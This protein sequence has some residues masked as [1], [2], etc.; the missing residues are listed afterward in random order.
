M[1][2]PDEWSIW[3]ESVE[4]RD[5]PGRTEL[6]PREDMIDQLPLIINGAYRNL[7]VFHSLWQDI[8]ACQNCRQAGSLWRNMQAYKQP[9]DVAH[10]NPARFT[11]TMEPPALQQHREIW[12]AHNDSYDDY[13]DA[14]TLEESFGDDTRFGDPHS[15]WTIFRD[16]GYRLPTRFPYMHYFQSPWQVSKHILAPGAPQTTTYNPRSYFPELHTVRNPVEGDRNFPDFA[17]IHPEV[18]ICGLSKLLDTAKSAFRSQT[19]D[20]FVCGKW[21]DGCFICLDLERDAMLVN[22]DID[23][24]IWVTPKLHVADTISIALTPTMGTAPPI[25]KNNHVYSRS[26][27]R[28]WNNTLMTPISVIPHTV[29][30]KLSEGDTPMFIYICFPR[31]L[32]RDD[33]GRREALMPFEVQRK[34]WDNVLLPALRSH[35]GLVSHAYGS[36]TVDDAQRSGHLFRAKTVAVENTNTIKNDP[37]LSPYGSFF[38]HQTHVAVPDISPINTPLSRLQKRF[39]SLDNGELTIDVDSMADNEPLTGL[40]RLEVLEQ[41]FAAGGFNRGQQ[42]N[43]GTLSRYGALQAPMARERSYLTHITFRSAYNLQYEMTRPSDNRPFFA[44]DGN[45]YDVNETYMNECQCRISLFRGKSVNTTYGVRDEYRV[46]G[47]AVMDIFTK[48]AQ[49]TRDFL[50][51]NPV[52]WIPTK[53]WFDFCAWRVEE[54]QSLQIHLSRLLPPNYG[55][56]TSLLCYMLQHVTNTPQIIFPH[57]RHSL[58]L[59]AAQ[60]IINRFGALFLHTLDLT[61]L[62]VIPEIEE[63]DD[64]D[65]RRCLGYA[66]RVRARKRR[67]PHQV[68]LDPSLA[69]PLGPSP[70]WSELVQCIEGRPETIMKEWSFDPFVDVNPTA[71]KLFVAFTQHIWHLLRP[72]WLC[73]RVRIWPKTIEEAMEMWSISG[74][75]DRILRI[76]FTACNAGLRGSIVA[77]R[78]P[79]FQDRV[80]LYFPPPGRAPPKGSQWYI[81]QQ[82][83][84]YIAL[85]HSA[86]SSLDDAGRDDL[87]SALSYMFTRIQCLPASSAPTGDSYG[88]VWKKEGDAIIIVTNPEPHEDPEPHFLSRPSGAASSRALP[89]MKTQMWPGHTL[90]TLPRI[91]PENQMQSGQQRLKTRNVP[92]K[93]ARG[94]QKQEA[95]LRNRYL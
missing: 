86:L 75:N 48:A 67:H 10:A 90:A 36:T 4:G 72:S 19:R 30:G 91:S 85:Y 73:P 42:H 44:E 8:L 38:F 40:W 71:T 3:Q 92:L 21:L 15:S 7:D 26:R 5:D 63:V 12:V 35:A 29:F 55:I 17:Q 53:L 13:F 32:H 88:W 39:P 59:L 23:S 31:M 2:L 60:Q 50:D 37:D 16:Y 6:V 43:I 77:Q 68:N 95:L 57:V 69:Y 89:L 66:K 1:D 28:S 45:A 58:A 11:R 76:S 78:E 93:R 82:Q 70:S 27:S 74:L 18:K 81:L 56:I 41:S 46:G 9:Q 33:R 49:M 52:L 47:Q 84:C 64:D 80:A 22:V 34:F 24:I 83:P 25:R 61:N 79:S 14:P 54:L 94:R 87:H 62:H 65:V 20:M 51:S